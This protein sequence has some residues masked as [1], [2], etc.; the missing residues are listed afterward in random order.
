M[1][2]IT[3]SQ[4]ADGSL[5]N[6]SLSIPVKWEQNISQAF[7][8]EQIRRMAIRFFPIPQDVFRCLFVSG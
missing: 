5:I 7:Y 2:W 3:L 4:L 8:P 6:A 1:P